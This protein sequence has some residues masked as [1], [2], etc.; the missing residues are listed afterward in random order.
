M[1]HTIGIAS[2]LAAVCAQALKVV[3]PLL[4]KRELRLLRIFDNGG[5]PSSH[6]ALV[7]TLTFGVGSY[8]GVASSLF[9][10]T[11]LF[12]MYIVF[13]AAGLRKEV[14]NQAQVLNELVD[15]LR[16]THHIDRSRLKELIGHTWGEVIAGFLLGLAAS[17]IAF[18]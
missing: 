12:S 4:H 15:E 11:L 1:I 13:E 14:G 17:L 2:L 3:I 9:S 18:Q 5:M 8:A 10:V 6:T 7:T 16:S